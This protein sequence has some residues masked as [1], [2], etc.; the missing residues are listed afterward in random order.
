[1]EW[2]HYWLTLAIILLIIWFLSW[3]YQPWKNLKYRDIDV[4]NYQNLNS[5]ECQVNSMQE[6]TPEPEFPPEPEP[7][8]E[9]QSELSVDPR[10]YDCIPKKT[11]G[12][13]G[14]NKCRIYLRRRF[15]Y[16]FNTCRPVFLKNPKTGYNLELDCYSPELRLAVEYQGPDHYP[17]M[18]INRYGKSV[19]Q[20]MYQL[21]KDKFKLE[22]CNRMGVWLITVPYTVDLNDVGDYIEARLP[23]HLAALP[24]A[25]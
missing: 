6:F 9:L 5:E 4:S 15:G 11:M 2:G 18:G 25:Y 1:M 13:I 12:G 3:W 10:I 19:A 16:D 8:S 21:Q 14:E 22:M 17:H 7:Q 23:P 20:Q 24:F